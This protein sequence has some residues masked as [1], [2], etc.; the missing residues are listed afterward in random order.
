M[1]ASGHGH[2]HCGHHIEARSKHLS[3]TNLRNLVSMVRSIFRDAALDRL[4]AENPAARVTLPSYERPLI[5]PLTVEQIRALEDVIDPR[6]RA[7]VTVQTGAGLRIGELLTLCVQDV[8]FLRKTIRV[9][10]QFAQTDS[11][12]R[13][14]P[15]TPRSK[16]VI[17]VPSSSSTP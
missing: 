7:T 4:C 15:K 16:R 14:D 8:D 9:R 5:V 11:K 3:P 1:A 13:T 6:C 10:Y 2:L 17:P 12:E